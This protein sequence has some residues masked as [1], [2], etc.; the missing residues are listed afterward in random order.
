MDG[1]VLEAGASLAD[2]VLGPRAKIGKGARL[3]ECNVQGGFV[4]EDGVEAKGETMVGF[5]GLEE[6]E[7]GE[8]GID[9]GV[10]GDEGE[11]GGIEI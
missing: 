6:G 1:V 8:L 11:G 10:G 9:L 5:D 4:V 3:V 2:C 7:N